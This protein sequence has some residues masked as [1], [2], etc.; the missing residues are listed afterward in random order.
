MSIERKMTRG[1]Y[2][3]LDC[4]PPHGWTLLTPVTIQLYGPKA[5]LEVMAWCH[6]AFGVHETHELEPWILTHVPT[7]LRIHS[8]EAMQDAVRFAQIIEPLADWAAITKKVKRG[9]SLFPQVRD[10]LISF[11]EVSSASLALSSADRE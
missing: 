2:E 10:A 5:K 6:G 7:G 9:S 4:P 1:F 3:T 11:K 8:F